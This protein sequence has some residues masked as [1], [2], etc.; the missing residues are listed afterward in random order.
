[1]CLYAAH[2]DQGSARSS[3]ATCLLLRMASGKIIKLVVFELLEF[4]AFSVPTL[5]IMEQ[6]ATAYQGTKNGSE[7][8]HY[9]L[10]VS[11]SIA[12]VAGVSLLIWVP[13]KVV[14]YKKRHLYKKIIGW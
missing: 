2:C 4:A 9:W 5:V 14:L 7:R 12:Y 11:C 6:F 8:T 1:M 13:I 3:A 10:I